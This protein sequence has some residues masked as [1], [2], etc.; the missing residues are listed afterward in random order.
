[1][2]ATT[3]CKPCCSEEQVVNVPGIQGDPGVDGIDGS[4]AYTTTTDPFV[5]PADG[6]NV[7]IDVENSDWMAIGQIV[8][9]D[10][11]AHFSVVSKPSSIT[12]E[13]KFENFPGDVAA[14]TNID[15][16]VTVVGTGTEAVVSLEHLEEYGSGTAYVL[17]NTSAYLAVGTNPPEITLTSTGV[18]V[19]TGS[20]IVTGAAWQSTPK[21][22]T[23]KIRNTTSATDLAPVSTFVVVDSDALATSDDLFTLTIQGA[24]VSGTINDVIQLWGKRSAAPSTSGDLEITQ[25]SITAVK[26]A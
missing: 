8:V 3:S 23:I 15:G 26:I 13:L 25:T 9:V 1:M 2:A 7:T 17:T 10:G 12:A 24:V 6:A 19:I 20:A 21:T 5:V 11:P 22:V 14:T 4:N 18:W 16:G